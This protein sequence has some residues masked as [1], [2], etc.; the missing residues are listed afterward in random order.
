MSETN[1]V[2]VS[3]ENTI[4]WEARAKKAEA[5]IVDMKNNQTETTTTQEIPKTEPV[6]DNNNYMT[7]EDYQKEEFFKNNPELAE[8]KDIINEKVSN[9]YS[10]EDAKTVVL[11]QDSTIQARK[12]TQNANFTAWTPD[13]SRTEYSIAD[14][15]SMPQAQYE[16]VMKASEKWEVVIK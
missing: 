13:F 7:R 15:E 6:V 11:A 16:K 9:G 14:L 5:K 3:T 4:D 10:L 2:E 12:T 8:H 1:N